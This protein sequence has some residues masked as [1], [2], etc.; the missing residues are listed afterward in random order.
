MA[1]KRQFH[2]VMWLCALVGMGFVVGPKQA[3][4]QAQPGSQPVSYCSTPA[5]GPLLI[6]NQK[7]LALV[8]GDVRFDVTCFIEKP[9]IFSMPWYG[10][11]SA[12][13][14]TVEGNIL[15]PLRGRDQAY[16]L[17]KGQHELSFVL[18][19]YEARDFTLTLRT[20]NSYH[21]V[22]T[23]HAMVM[24]LFLGL[25]VGL[26]VYVSL[27]GRGVKHR[28][29]YAYGCYLMSAALFFALQEGVFNYIWPGNTLSNHMRAQSLMAGLVVVCAVTFIARLLDFK[30]LIKKPLYLALQTAT[31][32]VLIAAITIVVAP[33]GLESLAS[34]YM[35]WTTLFIVACVFVVSCYAAIQRVHT[36]PLIVVA[37]SFVFFAMIF[38]IWLVDVNEFMH[39][40]ALIIST[41]IESF[42]FAVAASEKVKYLEE[43]KSKAYHTAAQDELCAVMNR[44]GW[45]LAAQ[46]KVDFHQSRGGML[47]LNYIDLNDFKTINDQ[48][49]HSTGDKVLQT[50]AKIIRHQAREDDLVGRIGGDEFVVLSH[51]LT[52]GQADRIHQRFRQKLHFIE[53]SVH[54]QLFHLSASVGVTVENSYAADLSRMLECADQQMYTA[55]RERGAAKSAD[56]TAAIANEP[57]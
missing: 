1:T 39:R 4:A 32:S 30:L 33:S 40:Y 52:R 8:A 23:L 10:F 41:A 27:L 20:V 49:G 12:V 35:G 34:T 3:Q 7:S 45:L 14:K 2:H 44:R 5:A 54:G 26:S 55:K 53:L 19:V 36:A 31:I 6:G 29:F 38:R 22:S 18:S 51:A 57:A 47:V 46:R 15:I 21:H 56:T 48:H 17:D 42:L 16:L 28:G 37:L 13:V 24:G 11:Q 9:A 25:C 50:V 43:E